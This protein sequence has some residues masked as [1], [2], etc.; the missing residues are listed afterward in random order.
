MKQ[1]LSVL[2]LNVRSSIYKVFTILCFTCVLQLADFYYVLRENRE[3]MQDVV[4][5]FS[6]EAMLEDSHMKLIFAIALA[7]LFVVLMWSLL[8]KGKVKTKRFLWRLSVD[9]RPMLFM[10]AGYHVLC[11]AALMAVQMGLWW[12][13]ISCIEKPVQGQVLPRL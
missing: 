7:V 6:F 1:Y 9:R 12:G 4:I 5:P 2:A 3:A 13:C 11:F 10:F 8:E